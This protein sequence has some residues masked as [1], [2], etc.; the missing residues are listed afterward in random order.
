MATACHPVNASLARRTAARER[1]AESL[2]LRDHTNAE[3]APAACRVRTAPS[4]THGPVA[5]LN[6]ISRT[7]QMSSWAKSPTVA[8][9]YC[10]NEP[11]WILSSTRV[12]RPV[13]VRHLH[14][15]HA[16]ASRDAPPTLHRATRHVSSH[17]FSE[18]LAHTPDA[19][20]LAAPPTHTSLDALD[21]D[22][23]LPYGPLR[24]K[25]DSLERGVAA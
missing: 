3:S 22:N 20:S 10:S 2:L 11:E 23:R 15:L 19:G 4:R 6:S 12:P 13:D 8:G 16:H 21:C 9:L 5:L 24:V 14:F 17:C 7:T 25:R 18:R 1:I